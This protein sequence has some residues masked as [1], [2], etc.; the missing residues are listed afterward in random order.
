VD[1][2]HQYGCLDFEGDTGTDGK[3]A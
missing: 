1:I 3:P 2:T